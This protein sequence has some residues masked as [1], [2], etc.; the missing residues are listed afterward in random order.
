MEGKKSESIVQRLA[1]KTP[2]K[3]MTGVNEDFLK[4]RGGEVRWKKGGS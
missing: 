1:N 2:I 4:A 3:R